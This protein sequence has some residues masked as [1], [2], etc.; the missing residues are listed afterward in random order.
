MM[1][2]VA[3]GPALAALGA[4]AGVRPLRQ[5][6][7]SIAAGSALA[8]FDIGTRTVVPGANDNLTAVAVAARARPAAARGAGPRRPRAAR[9]DRLRGVLHGGDA[10]LGAAP[11][12]VARPRRARASSCSRRSARRS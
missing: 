5:I 10:R 4:L 3:A 7:L 8:F 12:P 1:R 6:G 2:L 11:R 9:L